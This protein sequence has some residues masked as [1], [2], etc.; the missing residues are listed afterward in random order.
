[1][2]KILAIIVVSIIHF[3]FSQAVFSQRPQGLQISPKFGKPELEHRKVPARSNVNGREP[4]FH[5]LRRRGDIKF[6]PVPLQDR[7]VELARRPHTHLPLTVFGE[8][9]GPSQLFGYYLV[10]TTAVPPNV[11][12]SVIPGINDNG[13]I[14]TGANFANGGLPTVRG[15]YDTGTEAGSPHG[16]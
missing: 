5:S 13:V 9:E 14:P 6:L 11:F 15:A 1:M 12:T 10:D 7:L 3:T 8:A 4:D 16:S 2:G